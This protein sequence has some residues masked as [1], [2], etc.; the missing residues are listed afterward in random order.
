MRIDG[1]SEDKPAIKA[2]LQ[3]GAVI[4]KLGDSTVTDMMSYMKALSVFEAGNTTKVTYLR[5]GK[6]VTSEIKF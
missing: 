6:E 4:V 5:D 3:K 2:G 1:V